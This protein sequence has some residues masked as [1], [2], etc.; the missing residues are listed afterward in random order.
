MKVKKVSLEPYMSTSHSVAISESNM[1]PS[2]PL[3]IEKGEKLMQAP[4]AAHQAPILNTRKMLP[5][6]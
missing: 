5:Q 3:F 1:N 6:D 4:Y 2:F